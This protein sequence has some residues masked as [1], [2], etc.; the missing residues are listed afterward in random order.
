MVSEAWNIWCWHTNCMPLTWIGTGPWFHTVTG[1]WF[2]CWQHLVYQYVAAARSNW[3]ILSTS[4]MSVKV[5]DV[6]DIKVFYNLHLKNRSRFLSNDLHSGA[7][8]VPHLSMNGAAMN[9]MVSFITQC[10]HLH[11]DLM[12]QIAFAYC[13]KLKSYLPLKTGI[14]WLCWQTNRTLHLSGRNQYEGGM[15]TAQYLLPFL[16]GEPYLQ[17]SARKESTILACAC[18]FTKR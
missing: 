14:Q 6:S 18:R 8:K 17:R 13:I 4:A 7:T 15:S 3:I 11:V 2:C 1:N 12:L 10:L 16:T 5:V 9:E